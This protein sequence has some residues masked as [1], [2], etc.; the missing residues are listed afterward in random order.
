M[1][2]IALPGVES[3]DLQATAH[4]VATTP[5][6]AFAGVSKRFRNGT[7]A[8]DNVSWSIA[9]GSRVCLLGPNGAGKSTAI[10]LLEGAILPTTGS[11][12]LLGTSVSGAE[13]LDARRRTGIVP[14]NPGMYPD[15]TT[16]EYL[17]LIRRLYGRGDVD[18]TVE[19]FGL[20]EHR[21]A[22]MSQLSGGYQRRAVL[23]GALLCEP[24][25]LLL[26]EPTVGLDP[27]AA[28]DVC[29][30]LRNAMRGR[31]TLL[32]THNLAEA[33]ALCDEVVILRGGKVLVHAPLADLRL[34]TLPQLQ[35][36]ARQGAVMLGAA[37]RERG[38]DPSVVNG[39][40]MVIPRPD[41]KDGVA[42]L[43]RSLITDGLDVY[44]SHSIAVSLEDMFLDLV[45]S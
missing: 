32:C 29:N 10:R 12:R 1:Q 34:Q 28:S 26:D 30:L 14:Q 44:E 11:V 18:S 33:E 22:R 38:L 45:R 23:A 27:V 37:L 35:L 20:T 43:V 36:A 42:A 40:V 8:L 4:P 7:L 39:D 15:L 19:A 17:K 31:T 13:Y 16:L 9:A 24:D 3:A 21:A 6:L 2:T 25:L 5:A 41:G